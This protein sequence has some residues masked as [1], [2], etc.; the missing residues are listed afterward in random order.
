MGDGTTDRRS[1]SFK[2]VKVKATAK[3]TDIFTSRNHVLALDNDGNAWGWGANYYGQMGDGTVD[4]QTVPVRV[5]SSVKFASLFAGYEHSL[6]LDTDGNAWSW[7]ANDGG[8]LGIGSSDKNL[9]VFEPVRVKS[10][11]KFASISVGSYHTH[12]FDHDNN[13]WSWGYRN[14]ARENAV[15]VEPTKLQSSA[16]FTDMSAGAEHS[17]AK[18]SDGKLWAWGGNCLGTIG[19]GIGDTLEHLVPEKVFDQYLKVTDVIF[20]TANVNPPPVEDAETN[21]WKVTT[22]PHPAGTVDVTIRW[23]VGGQPQPDYIL[24]DGFTYWAPA[25]LPEAGA[26][27]PFVRMSGLGLLTMSVVAVGMFSKQR[28]KCRKISKHGI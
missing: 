15:Y 12:A 23:T 14:S 25:I 8:V 19:N 13:V 4:R 16:K 24:E 6:G 17:L 1:D 3:F 28:L 20:D 26:A 27:I 7:G 5:K 22:P 11:V 18:D 9:C 21:T 10:P 2:L